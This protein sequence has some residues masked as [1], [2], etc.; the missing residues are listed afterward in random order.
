MRVKVSQKDPGFFTSVIVATIFLFSFIVLFGVGLKS[1]GLFDVDEAIFAQASTE[2]LQSEDYVRP[3][4]NGEPRYHKPPMIYWFQ[5]FSMRFF[6]ETAFAAR[7]PSAILG[8][9]TV[10]VFFVFIERMTNHVRFALTSA[11]IMSL[12]V[13]YMIV[14]QAA[15]ADMLLNFFLMS[16][17]FAF[18]ANMYSRDRS[19]MTTAIGGL[20]LACGVIAKGPIALL[21]PAIIVGIV[22]ILKEH[23]W[24]N[25]KC[26]HPLVV[27]TAVLV[28]I[29]PWCV[30]IIKQHGFDFFEE[31]IWV[32]NIQRFTSDLGNSHSSSPF[33]YPLVLLLGFFPWSLL[34]PSAIIWIAPSFFRRMRGDDALQALPAIGLIWMLVVLVFFSFSGTKL[35][36]YIVPALPGAAM[37]VAGRLDDITNK[38]RVF[39]I[40]MPLL[41]AFVLAFAA[42]FF[43]LKFLPSGLLGEGM[44]APLFDAASQKLGF[45]WPVKDEQLVA[46]LAQDVNISIAPVM[47]AGILVA[48]LGA[49]LVLLAKGY[50]Q[51]TALMGVSMWL[52]LV[53]IV[54]G[55]VPVAYEYTQRPLATF[56]EKIKEVYKPGDKV[57]MAALHKPSVR[58]ISQVPFTPLNSVSEAASTPEIRGRRIFVVEQDKSEELVG[59]LPFGRTGKNCE[60]GFCLVVVKP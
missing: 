57:Y 27:L 50:R 36:H 24:H 37:L 39:K 25:V 3:T 51:G 41:M 15:I 1:S 40:Y 53:L 9:L 5:S 2:M 20:L 49:G 44:L 29:M 18:I 45:E 23:F 13:L 59:N 31:F 30:A 32:H 6:G 22:A 43:A 21:F 10:F 52:S 48:G 17:T 34:I 46:V 7:L 38:F 26:A 55:V 12:N 58:F 35:V 47:I 11:A 28:G 4:Y 60:G 19:M 8:F 42:V 56:A 16:S 54:L 14:A 33:Y